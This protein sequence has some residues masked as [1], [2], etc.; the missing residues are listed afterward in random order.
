MGPISQCSRIGGSNKLAEEFTSSPAS[1]QPVTESNETSNKIS[2]NVQTHCSCTMDGYK[3][4]LCVDPQHSTADET[5]P[6]HALRRAYTE[7]HTWRYRSERTNLG[8]TGSGGPS[9]TSDTKPCTASLQPE[10]DA[11]SLP[12]NMTTNASTCTL[13]QHI[14]AGES[15]PYVSDAASLCRWPLNGQGRRM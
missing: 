15:S 5:L 13:A 3:S 1:E 8:K 2:H 14:T 9:Y 10:T 6:P 4:C 7:K 12:S 11:P